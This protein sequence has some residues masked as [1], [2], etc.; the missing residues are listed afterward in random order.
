MNIKKTF[1]PGALAALIFFAAAG[2][3]QSDHRAKHSLILFG[4]NEIFASHI[5]YK[6]PHNYQVENGF[7][8]L[9]LAFS[10]LPAK[11]EFI[12]MRLY[13]NLN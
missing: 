9:R 5:V 1:I 4:E 10:S 6:V 8:F 13:G 7:L 11:F 3:A 2:F 12:L